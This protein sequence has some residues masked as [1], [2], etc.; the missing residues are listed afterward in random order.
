MDIST[1]RHKTYSRSLD[2]AAWYFQSWEINDSM[3]LDVGPAPMFSP[4]PLL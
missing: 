2:I 3:L 1:I 4:L